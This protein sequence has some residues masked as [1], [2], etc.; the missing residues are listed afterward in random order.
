MILFN[1]VIFQVGADIIYALSCEL[2]F[3]R[4]MLTT[5]VNDG[6][7]EVSSGVHCMLEQNAYLSSN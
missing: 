5:A 2:D 3:K 7:V 4:A 1:A 6:L